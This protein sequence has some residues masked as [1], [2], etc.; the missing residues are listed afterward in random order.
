MI[1]AL[2]SLTEDTILAVSGTELLC[3]NS[4]ETLPRRF[5]LN[6]ALVLLISAESSAPADQHPLSQQSKAIP[7][8][9]WSLTVAESLTPADKTP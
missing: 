8:W 3:D 4:Q 9:V 2:P 7:T 5:Y 6:G 1:L